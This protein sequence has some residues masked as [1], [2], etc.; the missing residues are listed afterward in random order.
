MFKNK[1]YRI[2][3]QKYIARKADS[4]GRIIKAKME[5]DTRDNERRI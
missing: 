1:Y 2:I 5:A 3:K 4:N